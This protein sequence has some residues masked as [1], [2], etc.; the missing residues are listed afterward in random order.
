MSIQFFKKYVDLAGHGSNLVLEGTSKNKFK[1]FEIE[2]NTEQEQYSGKN[3]FDKE[4]EITNTSHISSYSYNNGKYTIIPTGT[5]NPNFS[6]KIPNLPAGNYYFKSEVWLSN[7]TALANSGGVTFNFGSNYNR[8]FT[9]TEESTV[10]G[11]NWSN[12]G[13]IEPFILDLST[14]QIEEGSTATSYEPYVRTEYLAQIQNTLNK[15]KM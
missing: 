7:A 3:L 12:P 5:G 13:N 11:F 8:S 10:I 4:A 15:L 9:T 1:K 6:M 2:G 14:L